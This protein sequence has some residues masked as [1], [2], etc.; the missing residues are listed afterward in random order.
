MYTKSYSKSVEFNYATDMGVECKVSK[1]FTITIPKII[2][3]RFGILPGEQVNVGLSVDQQALLI[4]KALE[5][6]TDNKMIV[7]DNNLITIPIEL[8]RSLNLNKG[9]KFQVLILKG[10]M[11][12]FRKKT[13]DFIEILM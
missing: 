5:E 4:T 12:I 11:A 3:E 8:R 10:R 13:R 6:S 1:Y 7:R 2:R 9:D